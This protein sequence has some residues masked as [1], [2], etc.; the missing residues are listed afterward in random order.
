M[1]YEGLGPGSSCVQARAGLSGHSFQVIHIWCCASIPTARNHLLVRHALN[2]L[3]CHQRRRAHNDASHAA[4]APS[5]SPTSSHSHKVTIVEV[6]DDNNDIELTGS[7]HKKRLMKGK[8]RAYSPDPPEH[9]NETEHDASPSTVN[10]PH[11]TSSANHSDEV[12]ADGFLK[13]VQVMSIDEASENPR[14]EQ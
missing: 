5:A 11:A 8:K 2:M 4:N 13:D 10:A 6:D 3:L 9:A 1:A 7:T 12:D 14:Q